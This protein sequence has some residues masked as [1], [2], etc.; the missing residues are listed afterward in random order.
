MWQIHDQENHQLFGSGCLLKL[1]SFCVI[2]CFNN[3]TA[4]ASYITAA[5]HSQAISTC[6][7][8]CQGLQDMSEY[9]TEIHISKSV[10]IH[11]AVSFLFKRDRFTNISTVA[12]FQL[13]PL[14]V[15]NHNF[16]G[17]RNVWGRFELKR[18]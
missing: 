11:R 16:V 5:K 2:T 6:F 10:K 9:F 1:F 18:W 12:P 8:N 15:L 3:P 13:S 14:C 7:S 17:S 4:N